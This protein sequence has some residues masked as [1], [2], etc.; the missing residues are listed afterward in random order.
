MAGTGTDWRFSFDALR[1]K[2]HPTR[3]PAAAVRAPSGLAKATS[4][5]LEHLRIDNF[6]LTRRRMPDGRNN[7]QSKCLR[8]HPAGM[9]GSTKREGAVGRK[10]D[11]QTSSVAR[12]QWHPGGGPR[13][14]GKQTVQSMN[15]A[16]H[17][18]SSSV[19][20]LDGGLGLGC[21]PLSPVLVSAFGVLLAAL[22]DISVSR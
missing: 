12:S 4:H 1:A 15:C 3:D 9:T 10:H 2:Q 20:L 14:G 16:L 19:S 18:N 7:I 21:V 17:C 8:W 11:H 13:I 22:A 6:D 5:L